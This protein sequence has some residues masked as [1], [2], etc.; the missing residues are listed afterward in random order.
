[1]G[2]N[3]PPAEP[4]VCTAPFNV[5]CVVQG[6]FRTMKAN[7]EYPFGVPLCV[8]YM[9]TYR[10]VVLLKATSVTEYDPPMVVLYT[11]VHVV[12]SVETWILNALP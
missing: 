4:V 8:P 5:V 12:E 7:S 10:A 6:S 11:S 3:Q 9:R 1:M 2:E